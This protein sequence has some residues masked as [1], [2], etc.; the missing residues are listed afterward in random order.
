MLDQ[1][2]ADKSIV[3]GKSEFNSKIVSVVVSL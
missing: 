2:E 3:L 1:M